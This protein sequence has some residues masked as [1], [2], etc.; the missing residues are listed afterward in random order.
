MT[1]TLLALS[2]LI[3]GCGSSEPTTAPAPWQPSMGLPPPP[4]PSDPLP[5]VDAWEDLANLN[6]RWAEV[7]GTLVQVTGGKTPDPI[8]YTYL[9]LDDGLQISIGASMPEAWAPMLGQRLALVGIVTRCHHREA[10]QRPNGPYI[11]EWGTPRVLDPGPALASEEVVRA[12]RSRMYA[13]CRSGGST[14]AGGA[15][16]L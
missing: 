7:H 13:D 3:A 15:S 5:V 9:Q 8:P 14:G 12:A 2:L 16:G 1:P 6:N 4:P 11:D 10:G